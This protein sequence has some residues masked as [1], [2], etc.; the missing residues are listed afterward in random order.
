M[1]HLDVPSGSQRRHVEF[2]QV[3][4]DLVLFS[5]DV[6]NG[7]G[8]RESFQGLGPA[9]ILEPEILLRLIFAN[10]PE[11]LLAHLRKTF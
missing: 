10:V 8:L 1:I 6:K 11:V 9:K 3:D 7:D 2:A 5:Q 4:E